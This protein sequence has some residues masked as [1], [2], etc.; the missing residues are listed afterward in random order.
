MSDKQIL[1]ALR[2]AETILALCPHMITNQS[3]EGPGLTTEMAL[4]RVRSAIET[5]RKEAPKYLRSSGIQ[6]R[7]GISTVTLWRWVG[8]PDLN[9]PQPIIIKNHRYWDVEQ[10]DQWES[11]QREG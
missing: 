4:H 1:S 11:A 6:Q 10:L 8:D 9:F 5:L 7:Y 2:D 3:G